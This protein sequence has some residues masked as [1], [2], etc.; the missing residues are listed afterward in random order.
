MS[1]VEDDSTAFVIVSRTLLVVVFAFTFSSLAV[2]CQPCVIYEV[3]NRC[4]Q[5]HRAPEGDVVQGAQVRV[6]GAEKLGSIGIELSCL[7]S[8]KKG[9][10]VQKAT[11]DHKGLFTLEGLPPGDYFVVI[12]GQHEQVVQM[13]SV[14]D[15]GLESSCKKPM[16]YGVSESGMV[17]NMCDVLQ[18]KDFF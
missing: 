9:K 6:F 17:G 4:S 3:T 18:A 10:V 16:Q 11:T 8:Y 1:D 5:V 12:K 14:S 15:E 2:A 7:A 13:I